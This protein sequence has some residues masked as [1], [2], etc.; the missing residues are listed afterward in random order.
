MRC[1]APVLMVEPDPARVERALVAGG[2]VCPRCAGVLRPWGGTRRWLR[3]G[4]V[5]RRVRVRRSRC[6]G[7]RVTHVLLPVRA[8]ARRLDLAEVIGRA[9]L[10]KAAGQGHRAVAAGL[11]LPPTTV[12]GWLRRFAA[13][14]ELV[15][16]H[17]TRLAHELDPSLG[18]ISPRASPAA[19][20]LEA[21]GVAAAAAVRR[22]GPAP[23]WWFAAGASGGRLL[24]PG[25]LGSQP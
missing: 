9:L 11:G 22:L 13:R 2:L 7:C 25:P 6:R 4:G 16:S 17:F 19:D 23:V 10:A 24:A 3:E 18:A 21:L 5:A 12:R 20:A 1:G 8:L 14:A 15:R